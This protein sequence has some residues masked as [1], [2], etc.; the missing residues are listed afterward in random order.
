MRKKDRQRER[1]R[2]GGINN[3]NVKASACAFCEL[4]LFRKLSGNVITL[5]DL[6]LFL[7]L[8]LTIKNLQRRFSFE[9]TIPKVLAWHRR[10]L[11]LHESKPELTAILNLGVGLDTLVGDSDEVER[12]NVGLLP[13]PT[14]CLSSRSKLN[15]KISI[16]HKDATILLDALKERCQSDFVPCSRFSE[17]INWDEFPENVRPESGSLPPDRI[18]RKREQI[19]NVVNAVKSLAQDGESSQ[20]Q[21]NLN[22]LLLL[23]G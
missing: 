7:P 9:N 23:S 21:T 15:A 6:V 20:E 19:S 5:S 22:F 17:S 8:H 14:T 11:L 2:A 12:V 1:A 3:S 16:K 10:M 13:L 4:F 18:R